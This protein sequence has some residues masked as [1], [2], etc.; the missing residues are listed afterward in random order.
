M[1]KKFSSALCVLSLLMAVCL[2]DEDRELDSEIELKRMLTFVRPLM[3]IIRSD[4]RVRRSTDFTPAAS[5][6][7]MTGNP[8]K[9]RND[10]GYG[11]GYESCCHEGPDY[12]GLISVI[13]LGLLFLFLIAL[14][15][16]TSSSGRKRRSDGS[17]DNI[18][19]PEE[20]ASIQDISIGHQMF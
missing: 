5:A 16:S 15:S 11:G 6:G 9:E 8:L 14:L 10:Y 18:L 12:L 20:L 17:D 2:A 3:A 13:A 7:W 1:I 19:S 4:P